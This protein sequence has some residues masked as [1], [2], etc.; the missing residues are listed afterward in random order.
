MSA[1]FELE[2]VGVQMGATRALD[3][4]SLV[5]RTGEV[6]VLVGPNGAGKTTALRAGLGLAPLSEGQA[7]LGGVDLRA[8]S[9]R[10]R[11]LQAAYLP[12]R[13]SVAWPISVERLVALGRFAHGAAPDRPRPPDQ[14]AIDAALDACGLAALRARRMDQISGGERARA[15]LARALAQQ[16]PLLVLDEPTANLDPAQSLAVGA[17]L[18]RHRAGGG[19]ALVSTHDIG[20]AARIADRVAVM[21]GGRILAEGAPRMTLT[22]EALEAAFDRAGA[23]VEAGG[24]VAAIFS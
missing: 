16:A 19:A 1:L 17:I 20:F 7:R 21:R 9:P 12:Q 5:V 11:A 4:V 3:G 2:G 15:H 23:L 18:E 13:A 22:P 24:G 6:V 14:V 8:L 10:Q